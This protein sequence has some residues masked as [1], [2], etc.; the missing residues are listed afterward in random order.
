MKKEFIQNCFLFVAGSL[1]LCGL[2]FFLIT[3][4]TWCLDLGIVMVMTAFWLFS[5]TTMH[6]FIFG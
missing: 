3:E 6:K 5:I 2:P 4:P 1:F